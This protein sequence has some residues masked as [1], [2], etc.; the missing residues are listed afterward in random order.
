MESQLIMSK[1]AIQDKVPFKQIV[2]KE[3]TN[4]KTS[5]KKT[6]VTQRKVDVVNATQHGFFLVPNDAGWSEPGPEQLTWL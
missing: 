3:L 2:C 1:K 4:I 6:P 5:W